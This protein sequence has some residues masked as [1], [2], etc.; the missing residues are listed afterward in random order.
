MLSMRNVELRGSGR[1][2]DWEEDLFGI[3]LCPSLVFLGP[4][5]VSLRYSTQMESPSLEK[6]PPGR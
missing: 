6:I 4:A 5:F 3:T 2:L 1:S